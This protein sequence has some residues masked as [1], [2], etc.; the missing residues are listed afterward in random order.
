MKMILVFVLIVKEGTQMVGMTKWLLKN[1][2]LK[3]NPSVKPIVSPSS[4]EM[5]ISLIMFMDISIEVP[6]LGGN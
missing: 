5:A 6:L 2:V 4:S 1:L 3:L